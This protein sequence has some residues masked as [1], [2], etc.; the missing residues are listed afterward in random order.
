MTLLAVAALDA[1]LFFNANLHAGAD[2]PQG[3]D[4]IVVQ[5]GRIRYIG[6]T[7]KAQRRAPLFR[8]SF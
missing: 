3:A 4:A 6:P 8:R 2:A 1:A 7:A 5:D